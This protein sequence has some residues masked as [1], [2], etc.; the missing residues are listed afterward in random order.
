MFFTIL[1]VEMHRL[2]ESYG[3]KFLNLETQ[4]QRVSI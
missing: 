4:I 1:Y 3:R 2:V